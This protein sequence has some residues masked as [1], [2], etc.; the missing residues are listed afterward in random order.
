MA[1]RKVAGYGDVAKAN[2]FQLLFDTNDLSGSPRWEAYDNSESFPVRTEP[3]TVIASSL[4]IIG[5]DSNSNLSGICL[6]ATTNGVP[7]VKPGGATAGSANPNRLKGTVSYVTDPTEPNAGDAILYNMIIEIHNSFEPSDDTEFVLQCRYAYTGSPPDLYWKF[8]NETEGGDEE[9]PDWDGM[10][11]GT[12]GVRHGD[13]GSAAP[14]YYANIP[15][16]S[17]EDTDAAWV[18]I[19]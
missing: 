16:S 4:L 6:F 9:T 18:V 3:G 17:T 8:N 13:S 14:E 7:G 1:V 2:V 5:N 10:T 12:D 11:P 19:E 15:V